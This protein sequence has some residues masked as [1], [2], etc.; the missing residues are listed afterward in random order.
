MKLK[1]DTGAQAN[2]ISTNTFKQMYPGSSNEINTKFLTP[3]IHTL[4]AYNGSSIKCIGT[5]SILCGYNKSSF[6][7][8]NF[9]VVDVASLCIL[10]LPSC[11]QLNIVSMKCEIKELNNVQQLLQEYL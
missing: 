11:E 5:T 9:Y 7:F 1:V 8:T 3:T 6:K 4:T 10:G 2:T